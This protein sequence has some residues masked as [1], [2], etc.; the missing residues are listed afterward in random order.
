LSNNAKKYVSDN[1]TWDKVALKY[2][3][4]YESLLRS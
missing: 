2:S 1:L 3:E 4:F